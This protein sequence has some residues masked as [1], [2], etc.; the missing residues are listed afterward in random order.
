MIE[1]INLLPVLGIAILMNI[2]AGLYYSVGTKELLF[3]WKKFISGI[4]K[5]GIIA[6]LFIGIAYCFEEID[7]SSIGIEPMFVMLS[8]IT[9]YV[10]KAIISLAKILG[11]EVKTK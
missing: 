5:A 8:A 10:S 3:S 1:I 9:L 7:L 6:S 2:A 11:I 4:I